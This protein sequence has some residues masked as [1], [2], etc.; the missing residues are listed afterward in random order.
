MDP[1][2]WHAR[3]QANQIGFHE[4]RPNSYLER[5]ADRLPAGA[6]VLVPL[7]GKANDLA[8]LASRGHTVIGVELVEAAVVAFFAEHQLAPTRTPAGDHVAYQAG[9]ITVLAGDWFATTA[10]Q[11]GPVDAIYDRAALI[12]LPPAL[13]ERYVAELHP[14]LPADCRGLLITLEYPQHEKAGPPF[15]VAE[16]EVRERYGPQWS[17]E[18]LERR[19][20]LATQPRF[21]EDGV[22]ALD[23]CVYRLARRRIAAG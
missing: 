19:D 22:T 9:E 3:W 10:A 6:R 4:G 7:C 20:I 2:F 12:A 23:T 11:L 17:V 15:A 18:L 8:Y 1:S 14:R 13:R 5:F 21:V 16:A